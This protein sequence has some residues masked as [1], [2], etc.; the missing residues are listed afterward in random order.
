MQR[1]EAEGRGDAAEA[2]R[3]VRDSMG[4]KLNEL[5]AVT[6]K[7]DTAMGTMAGQGIQGKA[8]CDE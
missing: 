4:E 3:A 7:G 5:D 2:A 1:A 8:A 6:G